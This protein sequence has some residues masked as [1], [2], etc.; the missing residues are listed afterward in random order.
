MSKGAHCE[1]A[2]ANSNP[3]SKFGA[4]CCADAARASVCAGVVG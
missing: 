4:C 2:A 3:G 1:G